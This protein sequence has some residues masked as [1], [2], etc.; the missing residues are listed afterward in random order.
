MPRKELTAKQEQFCVNLEVKK[1]SQRAAYLDAYPKSKEWETDTV[2]ENACRLANNSKVLAR[3]KE[4]RGEQ[5][6]EIKQEAKWT[7]EDAHS[8]LT[9]LL[10]RAKR[11]I[12][13]KGE[14][15]SALVTAIVSTVKELNVIFAVGEK[16]EGGGV[17]EDILKAVR[18]IDND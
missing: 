5:L 11:E 1:M 12:E 2:D 13:E 16:S 14:I 8:N 15:S 9:W 4:L 17:L 7:R 6:E 18:G 10:E 3:R